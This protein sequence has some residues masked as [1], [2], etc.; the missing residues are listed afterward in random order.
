MLVHCWMAISRSTAAAVS[1]AC[2]ADAARS[3]IDIALA[4]RTA[5]PTATPNPRIIAEADGLLA[6]GGRLVAAAA[7]IGRGAPAMAGTPFRLQVRPAS[8]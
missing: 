8:A 5:S 3:E 6:R 7:S 2:A 1:L 4:L